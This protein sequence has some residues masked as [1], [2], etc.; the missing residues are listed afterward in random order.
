MV[1]QTTTK[2]FAV[3]TDPHLHNMIP[4]SISA[5]QIK[6]NGNLMSIFIKIVIMHTK[7]PFSN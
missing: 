3:K 7:V 2:L 1:T 6:L 4:T 5:R